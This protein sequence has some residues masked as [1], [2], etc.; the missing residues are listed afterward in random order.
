MTLFAITLGLSN[1]SISRLIHVWEKLPSKLRR[2]YAEFEALLDPSRNHRAYRMLI[3]KMQ[4]PI[5][6]FVPLLLK[7]LTFTHEGNKTY[8]G[9]LVN[10]EKMHMIA[11]VLR[12]FRNCKSKY[13]TC[14][15]IPG[16]KGNYP[17]NLIK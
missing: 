5:I 15:I 7:D 9:N 13:A 14:P 12:N 10:F 1:I 3:S 16:K 11:N 4:P 2:Q 6:P 17:Q 8:F